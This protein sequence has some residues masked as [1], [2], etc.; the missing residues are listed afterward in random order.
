[1]WGSS[2]LLGGDTLLHGGTLRAFADATL[3]C[4]SLRGDG[5]LRCGSLLGRRGL[6][7]RGLGKGRSHRCRGLL[8]RV[9]L[10][11]GR[12]LGRGRRTVSFGR[13]TLL[14]GGAG[15]GGGLLRT[16]LVQLDRLPYHR[17]QCL[18][19]L[20]RLRGVPTSRDATTSRDSY[21][22]A[23][24]AI[25]VENA[26]L[27]EGKIIVVNFGVCEEKLGP[28]GHFYSDGRAFLGREGERVDAVDALVD[29]FHL[30]QERHSVNPFRAVLQVTWKYT[31]TVT[32]GLLLW[33]LF[34]Y[35]VFSTSG[36][37]LHDGGWFVGTY[38]P[39][40]RLPALL[41]LGL[42]LTHRHVLIHSCCR[43]FS[44]AVGAFFQLNFLKIL[45]GGGIQLP[46]RH[47]WS[48]V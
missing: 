44:T 30:H 4:R 20:R 1:M 47:R 9:A 17:Q 12:L 15:L 26:M 11:R 43:K 37:G 29:H 33:L 32:K 35:S 8:H 22:G 34:I 46:R 21:Q 10:H 27:G 36:T 40:H 19:P 38:A 16:D 28:A 39:P 45:I 7:R 48:V 2:L 6:L 18:L 3:R 42:L 23:V 5:L 13:F 24:V 25:V 41:F 14:L 31:Y